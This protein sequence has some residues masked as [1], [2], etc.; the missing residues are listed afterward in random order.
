[1]R[2]RGNLSHL[3]A[4]AHQSFSNIDP[5]GCRFVSDEKK[6]SFEPS[7]LKITDESQ[8]NEVGSGS[9]FPSAN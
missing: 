3:A 2:R 6:S 1:M 7:H 9:F 4:E 8:F 5:S